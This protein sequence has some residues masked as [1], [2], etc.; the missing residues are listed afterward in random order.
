M[1]MLSIGLLWAFTAFILAASVQFQSFCS[2]L[3]LFYQKNDCGATASSFDGTL[4]HLES[5]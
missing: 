3:S 5:M 2:A 1:V 4:F